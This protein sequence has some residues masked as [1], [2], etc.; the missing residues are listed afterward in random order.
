MMRR[1]GIVSLVTVIVLSLQGCQTMDQVMGTLKQGI[2]KQELLDRDR[3]A[4]DRQLVPNPL[5]GNA[6]SAND[7][8]MTTPPRPNAGVI[9]EVTPKVGGAARKAAKPSAEEQAVELSFVDASLKSVIELLFDQYIKEPYTFLPDFKE[10]NVSWIVSGSYNKETIVRMVEAFLDL[11]GITIVKQGNVYAVSGSAQRAG[12]SSELGQTS[13][14]WRLRFLDAKDVVSIGRQFLAKPER[15]QVI[16]TANMVVAIGSGPEIRN[17]DKFL[18]DIDVPA[19]QDRNILVYGPKHLSAQALVSLLQNL[20]KAMGMS[21]SGDG[22]KLIEAEAVTNVQRVIIVTKGADIRQAVLNYLEQVDQP[23]KDTRQ[24]FVIPL[25]TQKASDVRTTL[26]QMLTSMFQDRDKLTIVADTGTNSL[27]ITATPDEFFEV[28]KVIDKLDFTAP[29]VL[30]ESSIIEVQLNESMAYGVEWFLSGRTNKARGDV[31]TNLRNSAIPLAGGLASSGTTIGLVSLKDNAFATLD[32]LAAETAVQVLSRPRVLVKNKMTAEIKSTKEVRLL[33]SELPTNVN[34]G[35]TTQISNQYE[36]KEVGVTLNVTPEVGSDGSITLKVKIEDS[37][38]G[39]VD[40]ATKQPTFDKRV[41]NT[42]FIVN[43]GETVFIGGLI[44]RKSSQDTTK[45]P[46]L[47]DIPLLGNAFSN[48]A[49]SE[50]GSELI[51]LVTPYVIMD[52]FAARLVS[53]AF[54]G[55]KGRN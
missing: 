53:E 22:K 41:I 16:D 11:H 24:V 47:G 19:L 33:K 42:D 38:Q 10:Q 4:I 21:M 5:E 34:T 30:I 49:T 1:A 45:V 50:S 15:L 39:S 44:K 43:H 32:L 46:G 3:P 23:G 51:V 54:A 6:K 36:T 52:H 40:A 17:L 28:K 25:R 18:A 29:S 55:L 12:Q 13:G 2:S 26:E 31:S 20:P 14:T 27:L 35:G 37:N 48:N 9:G 8:V 7:P